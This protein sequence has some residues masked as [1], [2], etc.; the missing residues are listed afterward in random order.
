MYVSIGIKGVGKG[1]VLYIFVRIFLER[2]YTGKNVKFGFRRNA[3]IIF[4]R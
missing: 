1:Y 4:E 3:R 2:Q